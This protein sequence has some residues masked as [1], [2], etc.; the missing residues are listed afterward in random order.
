MQQG[1]E[2]AALTDLMSRVWSDLSTREY[3]QHK[4]LKKEN[5]RDNM[6]NTELVLNML[7]EVAA[8]DI[9]LVRNPQ[10]LAESATVAAEGAQTA[11][12]ARLQLEKST[13]QPVVSRLNAEG[14]GTGKIERR[15]K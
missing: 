12:A 7:A 5:L 9:S 11:K 14:L 10:G 3:K 2:Y 1:Q 13:G 4:G 8:T 15:K 6:T